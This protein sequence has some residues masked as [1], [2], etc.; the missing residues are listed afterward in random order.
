MLIVQPFD[1]LMI[2]LVY[3]PHTTQKTM[4]TMAT[5]LNSLTPTTGDVCV[6]MPFPCSGLFLWNNF[7]YI[8]QGTCHNHPKTTAKTSTS[9]LY[10]LMKYDYE[11]KLNHLNIATY[12]CHHIYRALSVAILINPT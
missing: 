7:D 9:Y 4:V 6:P 10:T 11:N 12:N 8:C 5:N 1:L 2:N 3:I